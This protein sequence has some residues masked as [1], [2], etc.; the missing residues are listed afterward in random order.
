MKNKLI[1]VMGIGALALNLSAC[2]QDYSLRE[3][4]GTVLKEKGNIMNIESSSGAIFGNESVKFGDKTYILNVRTK[5]GDYIMQ[6]YET[7]GSKKPLEALE[8]SIKIGSKIRFYVDKEDNSPFHCK[9]SIPIFSEDK[10][11]WIKTNEIT[12]LKK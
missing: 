10:I 5:E 4:E 3:L 2:C 12:V 7:W 11:G 6:V 8:D 1:T 9:K